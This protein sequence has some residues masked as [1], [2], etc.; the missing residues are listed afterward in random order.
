MRE[1]SRAW[2]WP[3]SAR[4]TSGSRRH[5]AFEYLMGDLMKLLTATCVFCVAALPAMAAEPDGLTL[6][7][8]FHATVVT[9]SLGNQT[10]HMVFRDANR[11]YISTEQQEKTAPNEGI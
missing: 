6:P 11:L 10:R 4:S 2:E 5:P 7:P 9:E 8:G 3:W 1:P